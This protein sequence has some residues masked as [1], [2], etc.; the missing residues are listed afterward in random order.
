MSFIRRRSTEV[1][2]YDPV[3]SKLFEEI[4]ARIELLLLGLVTEIHHIGS[5]S[6]PGLCAK[7]KIDIDIIFRQAA[8]IREG[9][10]RMQATGDYTRSMANCIRIQVGVY[11]E[12]SLSRSEALSICA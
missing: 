5:T 9:I 1:V 4:R 8:E 10:A 12:P 6:V 3:W 11:H 2:D 7:P